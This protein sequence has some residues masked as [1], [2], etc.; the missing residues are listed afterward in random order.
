ME[1]AGLLQASS[2]CAV[3]HFRSKRVGQTRARIHVRL[4]C[5]VLLE[6][7][8]TSPRKRCLK[9]RESIEQWEVNRMWLWFSQDVGADFKLHAKPKD[10]VYPAAGPPAWLWAAPSR[11][12]HSEHLWLKCLPQVPHDQAELWGSIRPSLICDRLILGFT[13]LHPLSQSPA[14]SA[15]R[16]LRT[17][18]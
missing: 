7:V 3:V 14:V 9:D 2:Q 1:K 13:A 15:I 10:K 8:S 11:G 16:L 6:V 17:D 12:T 4:I 18:Q 5:G